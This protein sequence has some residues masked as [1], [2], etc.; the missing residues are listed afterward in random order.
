MV[1]L[2]HGS[3]RGARPIPSRSPAARPTARAPAAPSCRA[4]PP[5]R[6]RRRKR[7]WPPKPSACAS[8]PARTERR[9]DKYGRD[10]RF[11]V[12]QYEERLEFEL[13]IHDDLALATLWARAI[14]RTGRRTLPLEVGPTMPSGRGRGG[15]PRGVFGDG[16]G[17]ATVAQRVF[18][19]VA[20]GVQLLLERLR[21]GVR[22]VVIVNQPPFPGQPRERPAGARHR[23]GADASAG[24]PVAR[25]AVARSGRTQPRAARGWVELLGVARLRF[26]ARRTALHSRRATGRR[27]CAALT[28]GCWRP[29]RPRWGPSSA[30]ATRC[31]WPCAPLR[32]GACPTRRPSARWPRRSGSACARCSANFR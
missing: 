29:S 30:P 26:G 31:S 21:S 23:A 28:R 24:E 12:E 3:A 13:G 18:P 27:R 5:C 32:C 22:R 17:G 20:P 4:L 10:E 2:F 16:G 8:K 1:E 9:F 19:L 6:A 11:T 25:D 14:A 15:L 7:A